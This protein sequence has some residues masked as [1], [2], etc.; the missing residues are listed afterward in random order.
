MIRAPL[1]TTSVLDEATEVVT[2]TAAPWAAVLIAALLPY[3]FLQAVFVDHLLEV[4]PRA[5]EYGNLLGGTA[6]LTVAA[7]VIALCGRAVYARA[8]RLALARGA[9][10]GREAWRVPPAAL[11]SYILTGSATIAIGYAGLVTVIGLIVSAILGGLAIGTMELNK[12][13]GLVSPF[14]LIVQYMK[15]VR[16]PFALLFVFLCATVVALVNLIAAFQLAVWLAGAFGGIDAPRWQ[17]LFGPGNRRFVLALIAGALVLIEPFWVA[18]HVVYVRK[19]GA[20]ESGDD[21]RAWFHELM[22]RAA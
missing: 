13:A 12:R 19:A 17:L 21:L 5:A 15:D 4:G 10:P 3:R 18:A 8:S 6:N 22:R 14:R 20:D 16:I 7:I 2:M 1:S 11:G 9:S